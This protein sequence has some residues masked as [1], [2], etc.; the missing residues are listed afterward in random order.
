MAKGDTQQSPWVD[1]FPDTHG[2]AV[3]ITVY[4]DNAART[5]TNTG[6]GGKCVIVHRDNGCA[7][8]SIVFYD[9]P[10]QTRAVLPAPADGAGDNSYT[11]TQVR[12]ATKGLPGFP[13]GFQT[14]EDCL[15]ADISADF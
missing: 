8:H 14:I 7:Y 13:Q 1:P 6:P 2:L 5:L 4:F 12:N 11:V 10:T 15:A 9:E 3:T